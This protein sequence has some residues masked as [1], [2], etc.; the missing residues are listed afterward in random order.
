MPPM[1]PR[2]IEWLDAGER[3]LPEDPAPVLDL[4]YQV[5]TKLRAHSVRQL[6]TKVDIED[7]KWLLST[8]RD[9]IYKRYENFGTDD[10]RECFKALD[11]E[12]RRWGEYAWSVLGLGGPSRKPYL[13]SVLQNIT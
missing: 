9:E 11:A 5:R 6:W 12:D 1:L 4:V 2:G 8:Y 13:L 7:L 3:W 10:R